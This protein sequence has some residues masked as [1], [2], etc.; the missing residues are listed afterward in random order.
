LIPNT[1][2]TTEFHTYAVD[3]RK[4]AIKFYID[5]VLF[6]TFANSSNLPFNQKFF[7]IMN[8]AMG[9]SFGGAIDPAFS[10]STMEVD[11]VRVFQ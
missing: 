1:T 10:Q 5:D 11:Y 3:W 2:A 6:K 8:V 4:D 9:G 7:L